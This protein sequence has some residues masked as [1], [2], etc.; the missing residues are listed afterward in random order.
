MLVLREAFY[1]VQRFEEMR[2][3]LGVARNIL[4]DRL[5][6][7]VEHGLMERVPYRE[8]GQRTRMEYKLTR[9]GTALFPTLIAMSQW[10]ERH[11]PN[12]KG[13]PLELRHR[14]SGQ[15]VRLEFVREDGMRLEGLRELEAVYWPDGEPRSGAAGKG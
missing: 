5:S 2:L 9:K 6:R 11:L 7:L 15:L 4:T 10:A 3:H 13:R 12:P 1:G 14:E 8:A